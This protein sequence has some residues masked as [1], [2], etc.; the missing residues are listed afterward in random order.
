MSREAVRKPLDPLRMSWPPVLDGTAETEMM[1]AVEPAASSG[2]SGVSSIALASSSVLWFP[3]DSLK[4]SNI[5]GQKHTQ[6]NEF[7]MLQEMNENTQLDQLTNK[8]KP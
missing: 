2:L 5:K 3:S 7:L 6:T 8:T 4:W 1:E